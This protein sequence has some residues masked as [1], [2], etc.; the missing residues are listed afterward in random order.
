MS[1]HRKT[2]APEEWTLNVPRRASSTRRIGSALLVGAAI[3]GGAVATSGVASA[4][5][6]SL[7]LKTTQTIDTTKT[8]TVQPHSTVEF[9]GTLKSHNHPLAGKQV[10]LQYRTGNGAWH[11]GASATTDA[12]GH[13]TVDAKVGASAQ[14]RLTFEGDAL[15]S[16]TSSPSEVVYTQQP[17]NQRIVAEAAA[18]QGKPYSYGATGPDSFDCSGL[19][20][21]VHKLV[22]ISLP[23]TAQEQHDAVTPVSSSDAKPGDLV[24]FSS[25]GHVYH[26][27][28]YAGN[29][30]MW[31]APD[32]GETVQL[33][34]IY[35]SSYSFGRAW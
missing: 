27:G 12:N 18:Q 25:G 3:S 29:H 16:Q 5:Q 14:W 1:S 17:V 31:D 35:G 13:V 30:K 8:K 23:R 26:V 22:G 6:Q 10:E 4:S 9:G 19:T 21:Y 15:Y 11:D 24:F 33:Q 7:G 28:I 34:D 2:G 20:Q 32:S